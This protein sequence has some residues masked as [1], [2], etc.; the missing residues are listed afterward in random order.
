MRK[1]VQQL[2]QPLE[3]LRKSEID[4]LQKNLKEAKAKRD[5]IRQRGNLTSEEEAEL[6]RESQYMKAEFRRKKRKIE[7]K[8]E[9]E[10]IYEKCKKRF[11][12]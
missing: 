11:V 8:T 9:T 10:L 3:G 1:K 4:K 5:A 6:I 7:E 2:I 12:K